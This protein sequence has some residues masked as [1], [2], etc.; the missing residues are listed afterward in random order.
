MKKEIKLTDALLNQQTGQQRRHKPTFTWQERC[1][2]GDRA[3]T[4]TILREGSC[5]I[6]WPLRL[7]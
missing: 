7:N 5:G 2:T 3:G 1:V 6:W 4:G